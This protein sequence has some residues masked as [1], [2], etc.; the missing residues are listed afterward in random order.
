MIGSMIA[1]AKR[2]R[3]KPSPAVRQALRAMRRGIRLAAEQSRRDGI[4]MAIWKNGRVALIR[5]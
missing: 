4:P 3:P 2:S 1:R 5:P